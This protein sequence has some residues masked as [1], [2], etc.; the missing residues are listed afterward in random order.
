VDTPRPSPRTNRTR[1][2]PHSVLIGH[3]ACL[4][5]K[6]FLFAYVSRWP[7]VDAAIERAA[8][9]CT[10]PLRPLPL[11]T[12]LPPGARAAAWVP[13]GAAVY[14]V[15]RAGACPAALAPE[16][17]SAAAA[18]AAAAAGNG[19]KGSAAAAA[20]DAAPGGTAHVRGE[21]LAAPLAAALAGADVCEVPR[22]PD[23]CGS[24]PPLPPVLTG[25]V[26]SLL[27]Y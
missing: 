17:L 12:F 21:E 14:A 4:V 15:A 13:P 10:L 5:L 20:V 26:L 1:R 23:A 25:R 27:P 2:V 11:R 24:L 19:S 3:A 22:P 9:R 7:G 8:A 18:A 16:R 6:V